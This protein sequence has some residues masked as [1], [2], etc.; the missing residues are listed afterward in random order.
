MSNPLFCIRIRGHGLVDFDIPL[1]EVEN[2]ISY[3]LALG[4]ENITI[5][6]QA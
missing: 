1:C 2:R 6:M 3:W 5:E 4:H